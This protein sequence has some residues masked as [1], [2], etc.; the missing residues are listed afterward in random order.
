MKVITLRHAVAL[1]M[2]APFIATRARA[3]AP[4]PSKP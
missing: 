2:A 3:Q 4:W 1:A